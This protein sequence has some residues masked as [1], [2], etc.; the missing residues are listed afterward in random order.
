MLIID[1]FKHKF[2]KLNLIKRDEIL[3]IKKNKVLFILPNLL[4]LCNI[5]C[6]CFSIINLLMKQGDDV[7]YV[8]AV[9]LFFAIFFDAIDG[10]IARYTKT[11]SVFGMQLDSLADI[12]SFGLAPAILIYKWALWSVGFIGLLA[13]FIYV[14]CGAIRLARFNTIISLDSNYF[15]G[16][17]IPLSASILISLVIIHYK[18]FSG[19]PIQRSGLVF[20]V[21]IFSSF[22]MVSN[23][24]YWSFKNIKFSNKYFL[25]FFFLFSFFLFIII[26]CKVGVGL[27]FFIFGYVF[28]GF[29]RYLWLKVF[30]VKCFCSDGKKNCKLFK[31]FY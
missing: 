5:F 1:I 6:G 3:N 26:K 15:S 31:F 29:I 27:V 23:I 14:S 19:I 16:L 12:I 22:L 17:P 13:V 30:K 28:F 2:N 4:T 10:R 18:F 20:V 24:Q 9:I 25:F 7:F 11:Q 21:V 8:S